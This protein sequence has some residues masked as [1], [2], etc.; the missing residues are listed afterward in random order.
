MG[1][2][3]RPGEQRLVADRAGPT[4]RPEQGSLRIVTVPGAS[5]RGARLV[6]TEMKRSAR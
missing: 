6:E 2:E 4:R 3:R 1:A 5:Q